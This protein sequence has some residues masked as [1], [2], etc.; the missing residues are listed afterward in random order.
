MDIRLLYATAP[1]AATAEAIAGALIE[2]RLAACVNILRGMHSVYRWEGRVETAEEVVLVV[3]TTADAAPA[4]RDLI[5]ERHPY[6]EPAV[7]ALPVDR[8]A[9]SKA[10]CDWIAGETGDP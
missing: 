5:L 7:L 4:A 3:K 6:D 2:A 1:D 10:F 9:S 8:S